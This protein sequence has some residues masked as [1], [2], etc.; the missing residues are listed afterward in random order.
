MRV[1][2]NA[3][4]KNDMKIEES[5]CQMSNMQLKINEKCRQANAVTHTHTRTCT[6][7]HIKRIACLFSLSIILY[8]I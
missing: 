4:D 1:E 3:T 6:Q 5:I 2:R 8:A 7:R